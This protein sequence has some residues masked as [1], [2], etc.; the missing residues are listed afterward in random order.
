MEYDAML[1]SVLVIS[2][3]YQDVAP[4][5]AE[6]YNLTYLTDLERTMISQLKQLGD[7]SLS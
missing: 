7:V 3:F 4:G 1:Q 2:R 5:L 6:A